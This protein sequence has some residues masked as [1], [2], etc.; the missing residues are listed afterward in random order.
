MLLRSAR[1]VFVALFSL[2][3]LLLVLIGLL[4]F[5]PAGVKLAV[6]LAPQFVEELSIGKGEGSLLG[7]MT[8]YDVAY[9]DAHMPLSIDRLWW[10]IEANCLLQ[11]AVCIREVGIDGIDFQL[12]ALPES[13]SEEPPSESEP[14]TSL[15][16]PLP[17]QVE[18]IVLDNIEL[19]V[20]GNRVA[21]AHLSTGVTWQEALLTLSSTE[22]ETLRVAL[23]DTASKGATVA[24]EES[25]VSRHSPQ[26]AMVLPE[27]IL[28]L[29]IEVPSF[30]LTDAQL[31]G[32][33][34]PVRIEEFALSAAAR[35]S[36]IS[37]HSLSLKMPEASLSVQS[38][39]GL[40]DNY[41][42]SL[43]ADLDIYYADLKGHRLSLSASES[44]E[45]L[46]LSAMLQGT[47]KLTL[48][49]KMQPLS[50]QLPFDA[51]IVSE[52]LQ[53]PLTGEAEV[54]VRNTAITAMGELSDYQL[55]L[56]TGLTGVGIPPADITLA[57]KGSL[58]AITLASLNVKTLEGEVNAT[59]EAIWSPQVKWD[60][61]LD[62]QNINPAGVVDTL[63]GKLRGELVTKG[64]LLAS[65]G[66]DIQLPK[67]SVDGDLMAMPLALKGG[68]SLLDSKGNGDLVVK[69]TGLRLKH[70]PN[71]LHAQ[72]QLDKAWDMALEVDMPDLSQ[73][74]P[75]AEGVIQ[76]TARLKG[77]MLTPELSVDLRAD[78]LVWQSM[79][80]IDALT[81][82]GQVF[83]E[84]PIRVD[85]DL[86]AESVQYEESVD[87]DVVRAKISGSE[88]DHQLRLAMRGLPTGLVLA[89]DGHFQR[90]QGW[91]GTLSQSRIETPVGV[92][93]LDQ[94]AE[95]DVDLRQSRIRI[96][97]HCWEQ[98]PSKVC[99]TQMADV[100]ESGE[101]ALSITQFDFDKIARFMPS[102]MLLSGDAYVEVNAAW[103]DINAPVVDAKLRLTPG[104]FTLTQTG[105]S[106]GWEHIVVNAN[107]LSDNLQ[108]DW[109][110]N[111]SD[112]GA[113]VGD[114]SIEGLT[115]RPIEA[116]E[117][118]GQLAI[119][120]ID[121]SFLTPLV[122]DYSSV[123]GVL[124]SQLTFKGP[125]LNPAVNG[126]LKLDK[127][128]A[129]GKQVPVEVEQARFATTF[130]G[131]S[132]T[133][134][135]WL[136]TPDGELNLAGDAQWADLAAWS[137]NLNVQGERLDVVVPSLV[138]LEVSPNLTI[139]ASPK[140]A[141]INGQVDIPWARI[142]VDSVPPSA[143]GVS[144]DEVILTDELEPVS[145]EVSTPIDIKTNVFV[146]IGDDVTLEAFGLKGNLS[147]Q[148]NVQ[149]NNK[150]PQVAGEVRITDGTYR[151]FGQELLIDEGKILF[152]GRPDLPYLQVEAIRNP[153]STQDDVIA[154]VRVTGSAEAP[155]LDVFSEPAMPQQNALSYL[156]RG[157]DID[158]EAGGNMMTS[159]MIGLVLAQSGQLVGDIG[160]A[161]GVQE[162]TL[163]TAGTGDD[164]Q[165]TVSGY[166]APG[167]QVK[168]G[169]GIFNSL[170]EFTIRYR[171][172]RDL[173]V[174]AVSGLDSAVDVLYQFEFN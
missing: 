21:W 71:G 39:I 57:A 41:P 79:A 162:L 138:S 61:A 119:N 44:V 8:L 55:D 104:Q 77:A 89:V 101:L 33:G 51:E 166:I 5:T 87:L 59:A 31:D 126:E 40:H 42:L 10:D 107:L 100:G 9:S 173:Y 4:L 83:T 148:L 17:I 26:E 149:Q 18:R 49:A 80:N 29:A 171:L 167:L 34:Y 121:L 156:L 163:D 48:N 46:T 3:M 30:T 65:G 142:R 136:K 6:W 54:A 146:N 153:D 25:E 58:E 38:E 155:Q 36:E 52:H 75:D 152:S 43:E 60:A 123:A 72:G 157:R 108:A 82:Q 69:T 169:V 70:G 135:G 45:H 122:A 131:H 174:E 124:N 159:A 67:L 76:G 128:A 81:L 74:L 20:L 141:V 47:Q 117:I 19:D 35:E 150:G 132:A 164:S 129:K 66:Y 151:S 28:P 134:S 158:S 97:E 140:E 127:I 102:G 32:V 93:A 27:V 2:V 170:A 23:A 96:G 165:V 50:P 137:T 84:A 105:F 73:S 24:D 91:Q 37:V 103:Q 56:R 172:M 145:Q 143:V 92:W 144:S 110:V 161:F 68:V 90:G 22:W 125:V 120:D 114:A 113:L 106:Q 15:T 95:I 7:K 53:W 118:A 115:Q 11:P 16:A 98:A 168:Y 78:E 88:A 160:E 154:G 62:F 133:L 109:V 85:L 111:L 147:G 112:N 99:L 86:R 13:P 64:K 130:A 1:R 139:S 116:Q 14:L 94:P 63:P 12:A